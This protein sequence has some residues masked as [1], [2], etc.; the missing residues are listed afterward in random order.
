MLA[1]AEVCSLVSCMSLNRHLTAGDEEEQSRNAYCLFKRMCLMCPSR[2]ADF[3][4]FT[5]F[6]AQNAD[7]LQRVSR[8]ILTLLTLLLT[9]R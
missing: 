9:E 1:H 7:L 8:R 5:D 6:T 3:T 4:H 2:G